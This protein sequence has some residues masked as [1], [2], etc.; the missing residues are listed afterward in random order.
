M[1]T[2]FSIFILSVLSLFLA[3]GC[4]SPGVGPKGIFFTQA[5]LGVFGTGEPSSKFGIACVH[6]ILGL[7]AFG[8]G[9]IEKAKKNGS[10]ETVYEVNWETQS[11]LGIYAKLCVEAGG[12]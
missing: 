3:G 7:I 12:K 8:D 2:T 1:R 10:I 4:A 11:I 5:K 9:S 6:S